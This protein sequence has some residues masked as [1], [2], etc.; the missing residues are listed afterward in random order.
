M[1]NLRES[2]AGKQYLIIAPRTGKPKYLSYS[3]DEI[4][5]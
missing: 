1:F 3:K 4:E 5:G 2:A